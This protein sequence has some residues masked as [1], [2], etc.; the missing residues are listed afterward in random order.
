MADNE[1]PADAI[2]RLL[3]ESVTLYE[4][5]D[6]LMRERLPDGA[7]GAQVT[8]VFLALSA[9]TG[10][11]SARMERAGVPMLGHETSL[12]ACQEVVLRAERRLKAH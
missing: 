11:F 12:A 9:Y 5:I 8:A 3:S 4:A 10:A 2:E 6:A 7:S 1:T